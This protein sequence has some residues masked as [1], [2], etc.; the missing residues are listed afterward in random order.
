MHNCMVVL[1][2]IDSWVEGC[3]G[4]SGGRS[5]SSQ[6]Y[7]WCDLLHVGMILSSR[8]MAACCY[9]LDP[10]LALL[11]ISL[12][13]CWT[14]RQLYALLKRVQ[15]Q[16]YICWNQQRI[17]V[18][19]SELRVRHLAG[20]CMLYVGPLSHT[21]TYIAHSHAHE[22]THAWMMA[23]LQGALGCTLGP[24]PTLRVRT[25]SYRSAASFQRSDWAALCPPHHTC[26]QLSNAWVSAD[27]SASCI[28]SAR[29]F[30]PPQ[31]HTICSITPFVVTPLV[32][33]P[34]VVTPLV[35]TPHQDRYIATQNISLLQQ[36]LGVKCVFL[37]TCVQN[38]GLVAT[39]CVLTWDST[40]SLPHVV[41]SLT[42]MARAG[43]MLRQPGKLLDVFCAW[44]RV[45]S[46]RICIESSI[47]LWQRRSH[48][49]KASTCIV[50]MR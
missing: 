47:G 36:V 16:Q 10:A 3:A 34:L 8:G 31:R 37:C 17:C 48:R 20:V 22:D 23:I 24:F 19:F 38:E 33:T 44:Q 27:P 30:Q 5:S 1:H 39:R 43:S 50:F 4:S 32:V 40:P 13:L 49:S 26:M 14:L 9:I 46:P 29:P 2:D 6:R 35:V 21:Y 25:W 41:C 18:V 7:P 12:K 28:L 11:L 42:F 15:L 45:G